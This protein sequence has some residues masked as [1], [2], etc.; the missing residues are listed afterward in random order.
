MTANRT[1][2]PTIINTFVGRLAAAP[3]LTRH[4]ETTISR[5]VLIR[6]EY[7]GKDGET[8]D[9]RVRK[10]ALP[11]T[12]FNGQAQAL[13]EHCCKGD[14]LIVF[15]RIEN[16]NYT[17]KDGNDCYGFN[18]IVDGWQFGAPGE[19]KRRQLAE[20]ADAGIAP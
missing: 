16:N 6:N 12:A 5:F 3:V 1:T 7:A 11:L 9:A 19:T 15:F 18:F 14:Q 8:G 17:D 4:G 10:V 2:E 13:A 20:N